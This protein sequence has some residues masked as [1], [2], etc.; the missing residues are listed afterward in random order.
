M[1]DDTL[2]HEVLALAATAA[3]ANESLTLADFA[4]LT[5]DEKLAS[6]RPIISELVSEGQLERRG[7]R[8]FLAL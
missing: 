4:Q 5:E 3:N 6:I 8:Y 1:N 2:R 7:S